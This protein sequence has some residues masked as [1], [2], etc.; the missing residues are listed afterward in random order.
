MYHNALHGT[1]LRTHPAY[2]V[3][4]AFAWPGAWRTPQGTL[5]RRDGSGDLDHFDGEGQ[6][7]AS[8]RLVG[9]Q[10]DLLVSHLDHD[11][12]SV[13]HAGAGGETP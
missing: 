3:Y 10:H 11:H 2:L 8:Q 1:I 6:A 5:R 7:L 9:I 4:G 13:G 12:A